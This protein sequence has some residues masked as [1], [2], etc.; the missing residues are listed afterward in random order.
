MKLTKILSLLSAALALTMLALPCF[1]TAEEPFSKWKTIPTEDLEMDVYTVEKSPLYQKSVVF[2]GD[3]LCYARIERGDS[4][5]E[6]VIRASGYAGRIA[7]KYDMTLGAYGS[8]GATIAKPSMGTNIIYLKIQEA[9]STLSLKERQ[10]VD[11]VIL[12]GG[13]NDM[14]A[15]SPL[16]TV[17]DETEG[18]DLSTFAGAVQHTIKLTREL[19][20]NAMV[21]YIIAY[22]M[23][24]DP[25]E[26]RSNLENAEKYVDLTI[27]ACEKWNVPYVDFFHDQEFNQTVFKNGCITSDG[28]HMTVKGYDTITPYI[29]AWMEEPERRAPQ[30]Q[31]PI[32]T[33]E[34]DLTDPEE[35]PQQ[36]ETPDPEIPEEP[37][38]E[39]EVLLGV[40]IGSAVATVIAGGAA[41]GTALSVNAK[42][43]KKS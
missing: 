7:T 18:F 42:K 39:P 29:S 14:T 6:S 3:S 27:A 25:N 10:E 12:E 15:E 1:A 11:Y 19:Y 22:Q 37:K 33:P 40:I 20:P 21:G 2:F 8:S 35:D 23:P 41:V 38:E 16:G 13:V 43:K 28:V 26:L 9:A 17:G 30:P 5:Q 32:V 4:N 31:K 36:G 24:N 34:Q